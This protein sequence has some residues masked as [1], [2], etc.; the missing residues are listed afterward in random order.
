MLEVLEVVD[1]SLKLLRALP[2][3]LLRERIVRDMSLRIHGAS[4][5]R[6]GN[7][8]RLMVEHIPRLQ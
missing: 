2:D 1:H 4:H 5:D 7:S 6:V 8:N 3:T